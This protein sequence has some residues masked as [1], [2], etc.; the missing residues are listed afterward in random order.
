MK[1]PSGRPP[2]RI[3]YEALRAVGAKLR[4]FRQL[5]GTAQ[6]EFADKIGVKHQSIIS[7]FERGTRCPSDDVA[8]AIER[9]TRGLVP[10]SAWA[11][12][13]EVVEAA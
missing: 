7:E 4:A 2:K 1:K 9:E 11:A 3:N 5:E 10:A 6:L 8:R 12:V 13:V